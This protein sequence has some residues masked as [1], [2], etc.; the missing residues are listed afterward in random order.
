MWAG[1]VEYHALASF[2][3][4]A[5]AIIGVAA[6]PIYYG[7]WA[8]VFPQPYESA[9]LRS[10]GVVLCSAMALGRYWPAVLKRFYFPFCYLSIMYCLPV[11]FTAMLLLNEASSVWLMSTMA[12]FVFVVLLYDVR[13][14]IV[15]GMIGSALGV[16]LFWFIAGVQM[17]PD[18]YL[19]SY[20]IFFA[21]SL[22]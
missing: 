2:K 19:A 22:N 1:Y 15:V 8:Y 21:S 11:F 9:V 17:P 4:R 12:S 7:L 5:A 6:H 13:N 3:I 18:A 20:P 16:M 14:A 10:I